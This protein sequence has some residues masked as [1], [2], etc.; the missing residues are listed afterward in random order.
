MGMT[1]SFQKGH[2][3][4][5]GTVGQGRMEGWFLGAKSQL[6]N[7]QQADERKQRSLYQVIQKYIEKCLFFKVTK[8]VTILKILIKKLKKYDKLIANMSS[9]L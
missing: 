9:I 7:G 5:Q 6:T 3:S 1:A 2:G 4:S 8:L